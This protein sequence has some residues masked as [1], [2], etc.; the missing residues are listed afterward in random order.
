MIDTN[1]TWGGEQAAPDAPT[2]LF[3][4]ATTGAFYDTASWPH[5]L[6]VD[7]V[8]VSPEEHAEQLAAEAS[9]SRR[10]ADEA[11]RPIAAVPLPLTTDELAALAR[12]R[13]DQEIA[14]VQWLIERHRG[15]LALQRSTT[16]MP[17]DYLLVL[18]HVQDLRDVP[19]QDGFPMSIDWPQLPPELIVTGS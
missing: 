19:E 7:A 1:E 17:D 18:Q 5:D 13:R 12:R 9:G 16:L 11:G 8:E 15:E 2:A 14:E 3:F 6:P 4:S 10:I